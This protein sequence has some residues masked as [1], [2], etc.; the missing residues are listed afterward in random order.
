MLRTSGTQLASTR[1]SK[2]QQMSRGL[3]PRCPSSMQWTRRSADSFIGNLSPDP[4]HPR[5]NG[6][7]RLVIGIR[8]FALH[9]AHH[10]LA[11]GIVH[12]VSSCGGDG[13]CDAPTVA[14]PVSTPAQPRS[15]R[16]D[17]L[18]RASLW[19]SCEMGS[20]GCY[21]YGV[22]PR[23]VCRRAPVTLGSHDALNAVRSP[24]RPDEITL[25][26]SR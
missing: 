11:L 26:I 10:L 23:S 4:K 17:C 7:P 3:P 6:V 1:S 24:I 13:C 25:A 5:N 2:G 14:A 22:R 9:G 21:R 12:R 16:R 18:G 15:K 19:E 20:R 8:S